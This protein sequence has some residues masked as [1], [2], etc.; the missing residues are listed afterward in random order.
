MQ[1][2]CGYLQ[3][4]WEQVAHDDV[5][6]SGRFFTYHGMQD[7]VLHWLLALAHALAALG[8]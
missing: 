5:G 6:E 3:P 2:A 8:W 7:M 1:L 4:W